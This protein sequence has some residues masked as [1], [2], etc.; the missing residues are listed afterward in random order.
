MKLYGKKFVKR[1]MDQS[2][3]DRVETRDA[4]LWD[5]LPDQRLCRVKIQGSSQLITTHYPENW[6]QTPNWLKP[7][8]AVRITH[9]GG[10]RGRIEVVSHGQLIPTPV[11]GDTL[12]T[13]SSL[14]DALLAGG[15]VG[16]SYP[17][18]LSITV[19]AATYRIDEVQYNSPQT[20]LDIDTA[21]AVGQYR[22]DVIYADDGGT[23]HIAKGTASS[24]EPTFPSIP[25]NTIQLG[26]VLVYGGMEEV[27]SEFVNREW[28]EEAPA[29]VTVI[30]TDDELAWNELSTNVRVNVFDQYGNPIT[31]AAPGWYL[32]L[33]FAIVGNGTLHSDEEGNSRTKI[34]GHTGGSNNYYDFTYTR[35]QLATD[36]SPI[37]K[38]TCVLETFSPSAT[39]SIVLKNANGEA[40]AGQVTP[41]SWFKYLKDLTSA[42]NVEVDW[43]EAAVQRIVIDRNVVFTFTEAID[44][45]RLVLIVRQDGVGGHI[46]S[47]PESIRFG[48]DIASID[49]TQ[50]AGKQDYLAFFYD[51]GADKYDLVSHLHGYGE[52]PTS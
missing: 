23:V 20:N 51:G 49:L 22:Y 43:S 41:T 8:N 25:A 7:G 30:V 17:V 18:G 35:D 52:A 4:V 9:M 34:G 37:L 32:T 3:Q 5:V 27:N 29:M 21:P 10:K 11:A 31:T 47:W 13:P 42:N 28:A 26:Y 6:E 36:I 39:A 12:P 24:G 1:S 38:G 15:H 14:A 16:A 40:M 45:A 50:T 44:G 33:E 19:Q 46:P 48:T 2:V